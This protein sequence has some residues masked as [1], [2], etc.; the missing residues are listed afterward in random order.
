MKKAIAIVF[1][2]LLLGVVGYG[3]KR[4]TAT[5]T[6][7]ASP[8]RMTAC[9]DMGAELYSWRPAGQDWHFSFLAVTDRNKTLAEIANPAHTP[10]GAIGYTVVGT[11]DLKNALS[12]FHRG[13]EIVWVP[14]ATDKF[15]RPAWGATRKDAPPQVMGLYLTMFCKSLGIKLDTY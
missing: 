14:M 4:K 10:Y 2:I 13:A 11:A 15:G 3:V 7:G 5:R 6:G 1:C 12:A 8:A 9:L